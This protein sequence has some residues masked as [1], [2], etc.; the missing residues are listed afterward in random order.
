MLTSRRQFL[1]GLGTAAIALPFF[2]LLTRTRRARA[3]GNAVGKRVIFF[4][5]PD[6]VPAVSANGDPSQWHCTGSEQNFTLA[7]SV[8]PLAAHKNDCIFFN[9]LSMGPTDA[10]SHPGGAKKLLT[11]TD[12]GNGESI[13]QMLGRTLG[14]QAPWHH[15]YLGAMATQN[16]A[17]GDKFISYPSAGVSIAPEDNPQRAYERIFGLLGTGGTSSSGG[18]GSGGGSSGSGTGGG[19]GASLDASKSVIDGV[20][21]QMQSLKTKLGGTEAQKLALHLEALREVEQRIT[22][23]EMT[24]MMPPP[25]SSPGG[26]PACQDPGAQSFSDSELAD[27]GAFPAILKAQID[28][29]VSAMACGLTQVGTI[30]CSQHTSD[31]IMSRFMGTEMYD[32]GF[33]MRSHQASHYGPAHDLSHREYHDYTEQVR[34]WVSQFAYLLDQLKARPE[35][36][37]TMLDNSLVLICTEICDGN[38]HAHDNMPFVLAGRAGGAIRTGR[39]LQ[40]NYERHGNLYVAMAQALGQNISNFGDSSSGP[41]AGLLG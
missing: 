23:V 9:G 28:L 21:G 25:S 16:N 12:G 37:G 39:L 31:L 22:A 13:D 2:D 6:G 4:Y 36:D 7:D 34:W 10:G 5:F 27:P 29:M 40:Y 30:Q 8:S 11:A 14:A 33:D 24:Q 35:G 1:K 38:I 41:L 15:L 3:S 20:L 17:S 26:P 32:P 18:G 19:A